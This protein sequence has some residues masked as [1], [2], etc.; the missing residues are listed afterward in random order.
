MKRCS[1]CK[2][3]KNENEFSK[4]SYHSDGLRSDC[5]QC[6]C[7]NSK[8]IKSARLKRFR[9]L[10]DLG[11]KKCWRCQQEKELKISF[12]KDSTTKDG[13]QAAC[14]D[15]QK[16]RNNKYGKTHKEYFKQKG[17]ENYEK[18]KEENP[19]FNKERYIKYKPQYIKRKEKSLNT[20]YG[21]MY[22]LFDAART[23]ARNKKLSFE[24]DL[25]FLL[26]KF[27]T[28][29]GRC[30]LSGI[31][32]DLKGKRNPFGLSIDRI[33]SGKG[34]TKDNV[35]LVCLMVN[36]SLNKFGDESFFKMCEAVINKRKERIFK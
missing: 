14:I 26:K 29:E 16:K 8:R 11:L 19:N 20:I 1:R 36:L 23:R 32:F 9:E 34:Y 6:C 35:R 5:K 28:K 31:E 18:D 21:R 24:I 7:E 4:D 27:E 17:I 3:E 22:S 2:I 10:K 33:D 30:E 13:Y 25:D 12:W 15:C